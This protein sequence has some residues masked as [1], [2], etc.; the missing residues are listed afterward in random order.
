M[1]FYWFSLCE[2]L[3]EDT[4]FRCAN[5]EMV[6]FDTYEIAMEYKRKTKLSIDVV[7]VALDMIDFYP[8]ATTCIHRI[9]CML[10]FM[11]YFFSVIGL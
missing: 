4:V 8:I 10:S 11:H 6:K 5:P 7:I 2:K 1:R 3:A 9:N